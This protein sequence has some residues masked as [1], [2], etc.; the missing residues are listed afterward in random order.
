MSDKYYYLI[1]ERYDDW[2][3]TLNHCGLY[4]LKKSDDEI[5][6]HIF[7]EFDIGVRISCT[8]DMLTLLCEN[9]FIDDKMKMESMELRKLFCEIQIQESQL[10]NIES[11]RKHPRWKKIMEL[12]DL[13]KSQIYV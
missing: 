1:E 10:W 11:L 8:D 12:A 9:G 6:Y 13:I 3:E 7:E 2:K 5:G 4:L